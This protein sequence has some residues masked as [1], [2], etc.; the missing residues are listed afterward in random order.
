MRRLKKRTRALT[1]S[2][3]VLLM[4]VP[5]AAAGW[6]AS[7]PGPKTE[8]TAVPESFGP[9]WLN[10][11]AG[12]TELWFAAPVGNAPVIVMVH[13][14]RQPRS[15]LRR[16]AQDLHGRNY[17]IVLIEL[18]YLDGSE[19]YSGGA[20]EAAAVATA[21]DWTKGRFGRPVVL[22]GFSAGGFASTL[23][24]RNGTD[25]SALITD[26]A[27]V[28]S[29]STFR[30]AASQRIHMPRFLFCAL[31]PAYFVASGGHSLQDI[32]DGKQSWNTPTFVIHGTNDDYVPPANATD[33]RRVTNA[34][35]WMVPGVDHGGAWYADPAAYEARVD[36][37]IVKALRKRDAR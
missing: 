34:E 6:V 18:P 27:F 29:I 15:D 37:F 12:T 2:I 26:S 16:L 17:G 28:S 9:G 3:L 20:R 21:V 14:Y 23:A 7:H 11:H 10:D 25:V 8:P 19:P 36:G 35:L 32:R 13:G 24:V 31:R 22:M 1:I 33:L 30:R 5:N 4:L